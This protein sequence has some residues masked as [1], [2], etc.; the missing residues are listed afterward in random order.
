YEAATGHHV[1]P[2][3]LEHYRLTWTLSDLAYLLDLFRSPHGEIDDVD[4]KW[5]AL[6][7]LLAGG[8]SRPYAAVA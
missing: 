7:R 5:D 4:R 1:D 8:S 3:A 6:L 2:A